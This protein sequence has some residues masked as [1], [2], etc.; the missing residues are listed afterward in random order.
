MEKER[1]TGIEKVMLGISA[2]ITLGI[3]E[4]RHHTLDLKKKLLAC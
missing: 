2:S 1:S 3:I 4:I